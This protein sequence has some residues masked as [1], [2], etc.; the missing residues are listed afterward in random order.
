LSILQDLYIAEKL[1]VSNVDIEMI[2]M[3]NRVVDALQICLEMTVPR[4]CR[5][6]FKYLWC[7]ELDKLK[8][9]SITS[10]KLWKE[11]GRPRSGS[12]FSKYRSDKAAYRHGIRLHKR[13]KTQLYTYELH[14]AVLQ[15]DRV[16]FWKCWKSKLNASSRMCRSMA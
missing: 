9:R 15:K 7:Q 16:A 3:Y 8:D 13:N 6:F 5:N 4:C 14:E 2:Y 12:I 11:T 10:C 1:A